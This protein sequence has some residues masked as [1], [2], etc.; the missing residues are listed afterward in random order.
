MSSKA[1]AKLVSEKHG[2]RHNNADLIPPLPPGQPFFFGDEIA[3]KSLGMAVVR[4]RA[5]M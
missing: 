3:P 1:Q 4:A 5:V 2:Q